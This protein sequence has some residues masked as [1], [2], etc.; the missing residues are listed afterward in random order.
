MYTYFYPTVIIINMKQGPD[1][2]V[3]CF[4]GVHFKLSSKFWRDK[5]RDFFS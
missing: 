5:V 2:H 3:V 1:G 4:K